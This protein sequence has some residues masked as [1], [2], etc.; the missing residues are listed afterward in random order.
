[1][2]ELDGENMDRQAV[3]KEMVFLGLIGIRDPPRPESLEAVQSCQRGGI[4]VHMLTGD[5]ISTARSIAMEVGI[6]TPET[7][8]ATSVMTAQDF[9]RM[10]DDEI[11]ALKHLPLVVARCSPQTKAQMVKAIH[12]RGRLA[13]MTGDGVNDCPSL[14]IADVGIAMGLTPSDV[15]RQASEIVLADDN[16]AAIVAAVEEG[17]RLF[18]NLLKFMLHLISSNVAE[19]IVLMVGLAFIDSEGT[20][21]Y[22]LSAIQI[23]WENLITSIFPA[24]GYASYQTVLTVVLGWNLRPRM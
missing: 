13:A 21:V 24:F 20:S 2:K 15:A 6:L 7:D 12:R 17:R 14:K 3:E 10:T 5:H 9:D 19:A 22:P 16:F 23:L 4:I 18:D 1:M 11:D 8:I